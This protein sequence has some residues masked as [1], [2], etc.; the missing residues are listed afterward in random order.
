MRSITCFCVRIGTVI[1]QYNP[2]Y[3]RFSIY[4]KCVISINHSWEY[5]PNIVCISHGVYCTCGR[6]HLIIPNHIII[7]S[8]VINIPQSHNSTAVMHYNFVAM[9]GLCCII[10]CFIHVRTLQIF[11]RVDSLALSYS[12][13][14]HGTREVAMNNFGT[15]TC[16]H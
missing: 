8:C 3:Y 16:T 6:N 14:N 11:V 2:Q 15:E 12:Y 13:D 10:F 9:F 7:Y 1:A 5:K 4:S